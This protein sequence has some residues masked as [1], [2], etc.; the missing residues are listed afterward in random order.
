[1]L[2]MIG[3]PVVVVVAVVAVIV[4]VTVGVGAL[5]AMTKA[6]TYTLG[7]D[8]VPSVKKALGEERTV[9]GISRSTANGVTTLAVT[10]QV[11]GADQHNDMFT[12]AL[13]LHN[14]DNFL[15]MTASDFTAA[16]GTATL[17]R[18]STTPGQTILVQIRFDTSGYTI[19]LTRQA[20]SVT[21][22]GSLSPTP[23]PTGDATGAPTGTPTGDASTPVEP[24]SP[25]TPASP[26]VPPV[27]TLVPAAGWDSD[28]TDGIASYTSDGGMVVVVVMDFS[29][30]SGTPQAYV[31]N[32]RDTDQ[33]QDATQTVSDVTSA[34]AGVYEA[35]QYTV[36]DST[37]VQR[38]VYAVDGGWIVDIECYLSAAQYADMSPALDSM[39]ASL[40]IA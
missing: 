2:V 23:M 39:I 10:Y 16:T 40:T 15:V 33:S 6:D 26:D 24:G 21:P 18:D 34:V 29:W 7:T 14:T 22:E 38:S 13:Y 4:G 17:S 35:W 36:S 3:V 37:S 9:S 31:Q 11:S 19:T 20:G 1:M 30:Y 5:R 12:Y 8:T 28:V 27:A 32:R 25:V